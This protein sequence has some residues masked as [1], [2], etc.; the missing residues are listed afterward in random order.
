MGQAK[1]IDREMASYRFCACSG[2][3]GVRHDGAVMLSKANLANQDSGAGNAVLFSIAKRSRFV[4]QKLSVPG[5]SIGGSAD[6][7]STR[8]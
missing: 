8:R 3:F 2:L 7:Q 5:D 4:Q 6:R 1:L